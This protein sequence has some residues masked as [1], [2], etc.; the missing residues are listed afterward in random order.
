MNEKYEKLFENLRKNNIT[1]MYAENKD[2]ALKT[3]KDLL[4]KGATIANGGSVSCLETGVFDLI[5][6][7]EYNY[8]D[9]F[10][11]ADAY[12]DTV[13]ADFYFCSTNALTE[14]GEL[15]N[16]DGNS[17]RISAIAF[18]PKNIV[19]IV[20]KNKIVKDTDEGFLRV[21]KYAAPK[22]CE[23]LKIDNPCRKSGHCISLERSDNP[24]MTDGCDC[25]T[26]ICRNYLVSGKQKDKGRITL[27][28]VDEDL[29][30]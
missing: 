30:F 9:R 10:N 6:G 1:P 24:A 26:R 23:R 21:K 27:I 2:E 11:S 20:G 4:F 8:I 16:V 17:N 18:G 15:I 19:M 22:N 12:K 13:G 25:E 29:G 28:L 7:G 3:V 5:K 14:N